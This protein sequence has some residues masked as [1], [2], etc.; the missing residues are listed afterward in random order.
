MRTIA[1]GDIHGCL[2]ALRGLIALIA[3]SPD[4]QLIFLGD[5]I[6]RGPDSKGVINYLLELSQRCQTVFLLGNHE[7]MFRSVLIGAT[8][9][10]WLQVGGQETLDSYG[11]ALDSVPSKHIAFLNSLKLF[12]ESEECIFVHANYE[13]DKPMAEQ[14]ELIACWTHITE[15]FPVPHCS[16]KHV[17]VGHTPQIS[18]EVASFGNLTCID[19]YCVGGKWLSAI[20]VST[21]KIWQVS[22]TGDV[23]PDAVQT[24][25]SPSLWGNMKKRL[26]G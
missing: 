13:P 1:I 24:E 21:G 15:A 22:P 20:D 6:D 9:E 12:Y 14:N 8:T 7:I 16:G 18:G 4:D 23:R 3:P 26:F 5:Y 17:F 25:S 10:F 19:T 2:D 11:G